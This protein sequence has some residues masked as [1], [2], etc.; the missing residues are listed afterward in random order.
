MV[1][2]ILKA[3]LTVAILALTSAVSDASLL[4]VADQTYLARYDTSVGTGTT[5][6]TGES[7]LGIADDPLKDDIYYRTS[8]YPYLRLR[9]DNDP[10]F[11]D[12]S[13]S[14][15]DKL[16]D[17]AV[18]SNTL[19]FG[20]M[21]FDPLNNNL[22]YKQRQTTYGNPVT[23]IQMLDLDSNSVTTIY[24]ENERVIVGYRGYYNP[25]PIYAYVHDIVD[26]AV[27]SV[28]GNI[29]WTDRYAGTVNRLNL[30]GTPI[31]EELY[32]GLSN[33]YG[34]ALDAVSGTL[35]WSEQGNS[36][37]GY[38]SFIKYANMTGT[39][40]PVSLLSYD[41][42]DTSS[43]FGSIDVDPSAGKIYFVDFTPNYKHGYSG[44]VRT[45]D[46]NGQ[47]IQNFTNQSGA[48]VYG[49]IVDISS[50]AG[51]TVVPEPVSSTLFIT[52]GALLGFN[53]LRKKFKK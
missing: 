49:H 15:I 50:A 25:Q 5:V 19:S 27:D 1:K 38:D 48:P 23:S 40:S 28:G 9:R 42:S 36:A 44:T 33:P 14:D 53:R 11:Y 43:Y 24:S 52:G 2:I 8:Q 32:S 21:D 26:L 18:S 35:F 34:I 29:Y 37:N 16:Q 31:V 51:L 30:S 46:Y 12:P 22:F 7:I 45:M 20:N 41:G 47:N 10:A 3:I 13:A 4:Y 6:Y 17:I 39:G